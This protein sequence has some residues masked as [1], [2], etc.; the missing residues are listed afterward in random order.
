MA[1]GFQGEAMKRVAVYVLAV[2]ALGAAGAQGQPA[3]ASATSDPAA[4]KT[5]GF[6]LRISGELK[7]H[8]RWSEDDRFPLAFPFSPDFVPVGQAEQLARH[9]LDVGGHVARATRTVAAPSNG[10]RVSQRHHCV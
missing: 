8:G 2:A 10:A 7:V 4:E 5:D 1:P 3:T 9:A 6:K